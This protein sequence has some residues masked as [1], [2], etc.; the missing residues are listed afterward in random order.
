M[1]FYG[2]DYLSYMR[3]TVIGIPYIE[4]FKASGGAGVGAGLESS[5]GAGTARAATVTVDAAVGEPQTSDL[6]REGLLNRQR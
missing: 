4:P 2:S 1:E 5:V 6:E 3:R